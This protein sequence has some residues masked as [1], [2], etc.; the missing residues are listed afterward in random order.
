M[1][2]VS[3]ERDIASERMPPQASDSKAPE[4][5]I[6]ASGGWSSLPIAF[7][8]SSE[9]S[10]KQRAGISAAMKS[11]ETAVGRKLFAYSGE[12]NRTGDSFKDLYSSLKD[13]VNGEYLDDDWAKTGKP[14]EVLATTIWDNADV[15]TISTADIRFNSNHYL[16]FDSFDTEGLKLQGGDPSREVVDAESLALHELGHL[17]GLSHMDAENDQYSIMNPSLFVGPGLA[18]RKLSRGDIERIQRIYGCLGDSCDI[19]KLL[20]SIELAHETKQDKSASA[21]S[22]DSNAATTVSR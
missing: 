21:P 1:Y 17:L 12:D 14:D 9:I 22:S 11:W 19:D 2:Q 18:A 5:G 8:V 3:M 20:E 10:S 13:K 15:N 6:H 7:K 16:I 4:F